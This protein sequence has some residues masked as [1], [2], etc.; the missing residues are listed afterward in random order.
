MFQVWSLKIVQ[1]IL[2]LLVDITPTSYITAAIVAFVQ[3]IAT[4]IVIKELP[5]IWFI[6]QCRTVII[7]TCLLISENLL[8]KSEKWGTL[9]TDETGRRQ[10]AIINLII[11]IA[12]ANDLIFPPVIFP[13]SILPEYETAVGQ[14]YETVAFIEEKNSGY[15]NR[16][17]K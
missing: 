7:I 14:N 10:T 4:Y 2:E 6:R 15:R 11:K 17:M 16:N 9:Q 13:A 12:Q 1:L 5:S 3:N 8:S